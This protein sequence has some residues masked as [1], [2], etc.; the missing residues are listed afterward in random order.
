MLLPVSVFGIQFLLTDELKGK[1]LSSLLLVG[2]IVIFLLDVSILLFMC[3]SACFRCK[4][5][6]GILSTEAVNH[7][8]LLLS[9]KV[10]KMEDSESN[11]KSHNI[12]LEAL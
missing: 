7:R 8:K 5:E 12:V 9:N 3:L 10:L 1:M 4:K 11:L 6:N 2:F